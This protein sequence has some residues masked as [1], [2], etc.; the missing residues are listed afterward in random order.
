M[1][2]GQVL[3]KVV[4]PTKSCGSAILIAPRTWIEFLRVVDLAVSRKCILAGEVNVAPGTR[5]RLVLGFLYMFLD[6]HHA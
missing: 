5:K 4:A 6:L 1:L 3:P 2:F